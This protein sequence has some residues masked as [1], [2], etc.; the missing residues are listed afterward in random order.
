MW[1]HVVAN[2]T[3]V[4]SEVRAM[5]FEGLVYDNEGYYSGTCNDP[6]PVSCLWH[7]R[8]AFNVNGSGSY[9]A[10]GKQVGE[11]ISKAWPGARVVMAY[12]FPYPGLVDWVRGHIDAGLNVQ[13]GIEH[14]YGAG[15]C[16]GPYYHGS[17]FQCS[18]G[19]PP[20]STGP[21]HLKAV[22]DSEYQSW[23]AAASVSERM[24]A[25]ISPPNLGAFGPASPQ[26]E[27]VYLRQQLRSALCDEPTGPLDVWWWPA[28]GLTH[29]AL[30]AINATVTEP[31][32]AQ[33]YTSLMYAFIAQNTN[34]TDLCA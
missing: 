25:G 21:H 29:A 34:T 23:P 32:G 30:A 18:F 14:T 7:Q 1:E 12:G 9:Y 11:A 3:A 19:G 27:A 10:R 15:P 22:I 33:D 28:G 31:N 16:S 20:G 26:Y 6:T 2:I 5:G 13:V 8:S 17:W 24:T 4:Y